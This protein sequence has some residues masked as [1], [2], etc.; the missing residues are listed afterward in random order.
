V[1]GDS[2]AAEE[3][4]SCS[5]EAFSRHPMPL[6]EWKNH[7][8]LARL[9]VAHGRPAAARDAWGRAAAI[10]Q[11]ISANIADTQLRNGFLNA[12]TVRQV[13]AEAE[14]Y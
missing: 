6:V 4:L 2:N 13:L 9:L 1:R 10:V 11:Q 14:A 5:L 8:A 3:E 7:A 12:A